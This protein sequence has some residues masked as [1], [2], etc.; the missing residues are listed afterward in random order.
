MA[1]FDDDGHGDAFGDA[2]G[3]GS[4]WFECALDAV[5]FS[6]GDEGSV[7]ADVRRRG[8]FAAAALSERAKARAS[9]V[10]E[11]GL[12][13]PPGFRERARRD[14]EEDEDERCGRL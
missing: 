9:G 14:A 6:G 3:H 13:R 10:G 12:R 7:D 11:R 5:A 1:G 4:S 8:R 2:V